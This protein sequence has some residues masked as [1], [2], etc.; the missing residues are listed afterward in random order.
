[1]KEMFSKICT[2]LNDIVANVQPPYVARVYQKA[3]IELNEEY[4]EVAVAR[5]KYD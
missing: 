4:I 5:R 1:M 3:F 2:D